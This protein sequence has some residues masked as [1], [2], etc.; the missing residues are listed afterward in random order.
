MLLVVASAW[1]LVAVVV[2]RV[3]VRVLPHRR[4]LTGLEALSKISAR[5]AG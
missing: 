1:L 4:W 3:R 2:V 5:S